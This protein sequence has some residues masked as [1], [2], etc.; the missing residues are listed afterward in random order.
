M[1]NLKVTF[2]SILP[3]PYQRDLFAAIAARPDISLQ[4]KYLEMTVDDSPWPQKP[5]N[6]YESV[7]PGTDLRWGSSRFHVNWHLPN[8]EDTD[9]VVLNGYQSFVSQWIL[10]TQSSK[11]PC[12]FWGEKMVGAATGV[13]G[14]IQKAFAASLNNC[15]AIAAIGAAA[16]E[17][18]QTR[19][20]DKLVAP[21]PYYCD[22]KNFQKDIPQRPRDPINIFFCGQI[23]ARKGVD[24][25]LQAF[26]QII[27]QGLNA[28]LTMV[29][30]EAE[31]ADFMADIPE[32]VKDKVIYAGFQAPDLL[33]EFFN[34]ADIFVLPSRYDGWG[35]VVNQAVGAGLPIIC[36]DAVGSAADLVKD[37]GIIFSAGD[38]QELYQALLTYISNPEKLTA[39]SQASY[40]NSSQWHPEAGA[41]RWVKLFSEVL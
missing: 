1:S 14:D 6:D 4:V 28:T 13:K 25:L 39:A 32:S 9:V 16:V 30:R 11:I 38:Q 36:S 35:V 23:I 7:L 10:R 21:I 2:Y 3:S 27:E 34:Q 17:D 26:S 5:L 22:L 20:P 29:G 19:Y 8:F 31:F 33:P 12:I 24:T 15:R 37:N 40:K 18:Y 41:E